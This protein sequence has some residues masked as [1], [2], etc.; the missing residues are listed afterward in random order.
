MGDDEAM[1]DIVS[2][3]NIACGFHAGDPK[4]IFETVSAAAA[5]GVSIGAHVAYP[6][7]VGFG[8]RP[9]QPSHDEL[10]ADVMY[11]IGALEVMAR[12]AGTQLGYVKPH[13]ALYNTIAYD[14]AQADAVIQAITKVNP[15]LALLCLASSPLVAQA[16]AAGL[17]AVGEA[18]ADRAYEPSG[19]LV[20]RRE[21]G[22]VLHDEREIADRMLQLV[23]TST[24][25]AR[26]GSTLTLDAQS[27]CVHGDTPRAV[28]IARSI[29]ARL[30][31]AGVQITSFLESSRHSDDKNH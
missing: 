15:E 19:E 4:S 30:S 16:S 27:I 1:L 22:A 13:G 25:T 12:T 21:A 9:M 10:L 17:H 29:N 11:Q 26:D 7:L 23:E 2:S 24:L 3:A 6:D 31:D 8:R 14:E 18:F 20:S 5:R 28:Q